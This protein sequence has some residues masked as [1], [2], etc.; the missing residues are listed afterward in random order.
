M[1]GFV[2]F[3]D[4]PVRVGEFCSFGD[5]MGTVEKIGLR[6]T[7]VR[8][9][10]R[11]V[12]TVPNTDFAQ[13]QIVNFT[14]RDM[15]L[16]Q[17]KIGLRYETTPDQLRYVVAKIRKLLI[18]HSK[19]SPDPAR[20]RLSEIGN[21]AYVLEMFAFVM[22]ADWGDFLAIKEDLNLR[23]AEIVRDVRDQLRLPVADGLLHSGHRRRRCARRGDRGRGPPVAGG[24]APSVPGLRLRRAGGDGGHAALPARRLAGLSADS[25]PTPQWASRGESG[26]APT[27]LAGAASPREGAGDD[28]LSSGPGPEWINGRDRDLGVAR[29]GRWAGGASR[30]SARLRRRR[31]RTSD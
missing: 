2:L 17:C 16:F 8:G 1:G 18:Q 21:S 22:A 25:A 26:D 19:V 15:N 4:K 28:E 9:L 29:G 12:I 11:T 14:R 3:A 10:D 20:V 7:R 13:M 31:R 5:K 30:P 24:K 23:I 6:S 27:R